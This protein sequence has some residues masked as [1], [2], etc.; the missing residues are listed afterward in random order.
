[1]Q[2]AAI[3]LGPERNACICREMTKEYE[4]IVR[5]TLLELLE[6]SKSKEML[7]E[8]TVVVAGNLLQSK[9]SKKEVLILHAN[10]VK[11]G[12]SKKEVN[13]QVINESGWSK[14][15]IFDLLVSEKTNQGKR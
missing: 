6:W 10:L 2:D 13:E 1:M 8:F 9:L 14:R 7:G 12:L 5:G 11:K 3:N 4:E 15:E